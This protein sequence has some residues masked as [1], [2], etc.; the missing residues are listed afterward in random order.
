[1]SNIV[2]AG[3]AELAP[4]EWQALRESAKAIVS[5]GFLPKAINT[6][7][8]AIT[9]M[10]A[11]REL[12]LGP[13]QSIRSIYVIDGKPVMSADLMAALVHRK[14]PGA[15]LR[16]DIT[17]NDECSVDAGRPGQEA[18][19]FTF[20]MKDAQAAGLM[21]KDNWKKYPRAMLRARC[22]SEAVRAVFP[23]ACLG[24]YDPDELGAVTGPQGDII[25]MPAPAPPTI[26]PFHEAE[27][28][29]IYPTQDELDG[30]LE[31]LGEAESMAAMRRVLHEFAW[32]TPETMERWA[33]EQA[34]EISRLYN[35]RKRQ[36]AKTEATNAA[37]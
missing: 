5:S 21:S 7:E 22:L 6:P 29:R 25:E 26:S 15:T 30:V 10:M 16:V 13:M 18:T 2:V 12:G 4:G 33:P 20:S 14:I 23:D 37:E 3:T 1:M 19:R 36:F 11:G 34:K 9:I 27:E 8:K 32:T 17:T 24:V 35:Q 31:A 28:G